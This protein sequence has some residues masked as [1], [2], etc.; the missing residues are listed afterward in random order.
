VEF[1]DAGMKLGQ[2]TSSLHSIVL[3]TIVLTNLPADVHVFTARVVDSAGL[4]VDTAPVTVTVGTPPI[5]VMLLGVDDD[6]T[7]RY[8]GSGADLG[9]DWQEPNFDDSQWAQGK[10][11]I[12]DE[13]SP[14]VEPIRTVISRFNDSG[15]HV[16]TFY[17][18]THFTFTNAISAGTKLQIRHV[19]DD[20][21]V[22][23]LNGIEVLRFDLPAGLID[24]TTYAFG[25]ENAWE[26]PVEIP[27]EAL[28]LGDNV[29]AA[30]VHQSS[31]S[32]SDIVFGAELIAIIPDSGSLSE[33]RFQ[34]PVV[35]AGKLVLVWTGGG[36]LQ[37]GL[38]VN[39][40]WSN[41]D[42]ATS[43]FTVT[44]LNETWKFYRLR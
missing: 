9:K 23:Y 36:T 24:A 17:F 25:H 8:E 44:L 12:A 29:L 22:F 4:F 14:T 37:T 20:G 16:T 19:V 40:P 32:S 6:T 10:T 13:D 21:V 39:G 30:E 43:P 35:E 18:R 15:D 27:I 7:W 38:T 2:A 1:F 11:L 34:I 31:S 42:G 33:R 41:V 3:T 26:G 5:N 28:L